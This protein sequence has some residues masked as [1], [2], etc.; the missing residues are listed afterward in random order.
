MYTLGIGIAPAPG[1]IVGACIASASILLSDIPHVLLDGGV[2]TVI[3][4]SSKP[5]LTGLLDIL[6]VFWV[7][8]RALG[9]KVGF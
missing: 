4:L 2:T 1:R 8:F 9:R 6:V 7:S 5:T 3:F